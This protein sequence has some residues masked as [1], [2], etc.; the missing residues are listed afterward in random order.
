MRQRVVAGEVGDAEVGQL[1]RARASR[2]VGDEH[3]LRLD[4][5]VHD[6][7]LV[8][9]PERVGQR[10]PGAQH[11]A[12]R[13]RA[14]ARAAPA[15]GPRR[16]RTRGSG[17]RPP[18]R[19]RT[20]RRCP[21]GRGGRPRAPRAGPA[22]ARPVGRHDLDGDGRGPGARRGPRRPCRT[23]RRRGGPGAG[24]D[25]ARGPGWRRP[26]ALPVA[27]TSGEFHARGR[28]PARLHEC[29]AHGAREVSRRAAAYSCAVS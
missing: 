27:G 6:A 16:A 4:V 23:R 17:R 22:R 7:A 13:Q 21:G 12:V 20:G 15:C 28:A 10:E 19:R 29:S 11:V 1:R 14:A 25:R 3:V 9:V 24:S 5:A 26:P 18:R 2:L 8:R